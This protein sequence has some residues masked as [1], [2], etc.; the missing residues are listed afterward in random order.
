MSRMDTSSIRKVV[1][2]IVA[3]FLLPQVNS[4]RY[5]LSIIINNHYVLFI[6]NE[7]RENGQPQRHHVTIEIMAWRRGQ[8]A[9]S[10]NPPKNDLKVFPLTAYFISSGLLQSLHGLP[11]RCRHDSLAIHSEQWFDSN[12]VESVIDGKH[13]LGT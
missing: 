12:Q 3:P 2:L 6:V 1:A 7:T 13:F 5:S 4:H 9:V 11:K 10:E 8:Q